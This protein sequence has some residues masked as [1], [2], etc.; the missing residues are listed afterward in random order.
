MFK[1]ILITTALI[2]IIGVLVFGAI[3]R[4]QAKTG[5]ESNAASQ[6]GNGRSYNEVFS[7]DHL[8]G[9]NPQ[10]DGGF[11]RGQRGSSSEY[12]QSAGEQYTLPAASL[13]PLSAEEAAALTYMR[14]EEKLAHDV[15][16]TLY[17]QWGLSTFT[18]ISQ[19]EQVHTEAIKALLDR[20]SLSDPATDE[21]GVFTNADLQA[22]YNDLVARGRESLAEAIKVGAAIEE[23]DIIDL[24][25]RLEQTDNADIQQV[26]NNLLSGSKNHLSA[27]AT[28]YNRQTGEVYQAQYLSAAAYQAIVNSAVQNGGRGQG[29]QAGGGQGGGYRGGKP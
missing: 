1:K 14:E 9:T 13:D 23:I 15:Y 19:S 29:S 6:S 20:Y 11:G 25:K 2:A 8:E 26:F 21:V 24:Q 22:L 17:A 18:N 3:N 27:F 16:V 10:G 5:T 28:A 7:A 12:G 4:T